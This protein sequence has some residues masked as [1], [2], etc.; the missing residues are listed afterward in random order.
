MV[1]AAILQDAAE[2]E[3]AKLVRNEVIILVQNVGNQQ[4]LHVIDRV[5]NKAL[6]DAAAELMLAVV[7]ETTLHLANKLRVQID[8]T[9]VLQ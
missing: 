4:F 8:S 2:D 5:L 6:D 3:S 7:E 9:G 1:E